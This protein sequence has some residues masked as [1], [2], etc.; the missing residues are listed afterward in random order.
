M[1]DITKEEMREKL[2]NIEKI[3][4]IIFG[5]NIREFNNR[6][7][8]MESDLSRLQ[9]EFHDYAQQLKSVFS[10]DIRATNEAFDKKFKSLSTESKEEAP[11]LRQHLE[12]INRKFSNSIESL[13]QSLDTQTNLLRD[14]F[15]QT[16]KLEIGGKKTLG[17]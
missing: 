3:R 9:Q 5:S 17:I 6:F 11:E 4:D 10:T 14:E 13:D 16:S 8:K 2:A 1:S 15:N 7:E 12:R